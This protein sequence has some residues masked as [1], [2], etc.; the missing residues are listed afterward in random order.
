MAATTMNTEETVP[1]IW[2]ECQPPSDRVLKLWSE[3]GNKLDKESTVVW[4]QAVETLQEANNYLR[5][6]REARDFVEQY[7]V[8]IV[9]ILLD[10]QPLKVGNNERRCVEESLTLAVTIISNDLEI[11][12]ERGRRAPRGP[13]GV[14]CRT[15]D[16]LACVFCKKKQYYKG[17]K[18]SWNVNH[19]SGLPL[20]RL[21]LA[22]K[23]LEE[24]GFARLVEYMSD[25]TIGDEDSSAIGTGDP[26]GGDN[27]AL[28]PMASV[29]SPQQQQHSQQALALLASS[30][31]SFPTIDLLHQVLTV[32]LDVYNTN[33][34]KNDEKRLRALEQAAIDVSKATMRYISSCSEEALKKIPMEDL[35]LLVHDLLRIFDKLIEFRRPDTYDFYSFWRGLVLKLITSQSL[36]LKL[37]GWQQVETLLEASAAHR[38]PPRSFV[39]ELAG[40][41]FVNG[42][43]HFKGV[44]TEDGYGLRSGNNEISYVREIPDD[45]PVNSGK[46]LT[47]FRCTM[48]SQ[49]KW[50][51]LSEADE[52]Q[53][54]TDR[55]IDYY[56]HKSKEHEETEPPLS[57]WL[58]CR[59]A[60][61][62][63][64]PKLVRI[65]LMVP[66]GEERNTLEHQLARWAIDNKIIETLVLGDSVHREIVSRSVPLIK[67]L[68]SMC[69]RDNGVTETI[70]N[71]DNVA[72]TED[73]VVEKADDSAEYC[74]QTSHLLLAWK[75]CTRK[76]DAAVSA[77]IYQLLVSIL[78]SCPV[79]LAVVLLKAVQQSLIQG[80]SVGITNGGN[81]NNDCLTEVSD[82]C[83]ALAVANSND[84]PAYN[85]NNNSNRGTTS[86]Q[87]SNDARA[88]VLKLLWSL[89]IHPE[90]SSLKSYDLLKQYV[91]REL[92]VE[93]GGNEH[94]E[95]YLRSCIAA[96]QENSKRQTSGTVD[97]IRALKMV[98]L[99]HF[100]LEAC[101]RVQAA[102]LV[103]SDQGGLPLLLFDELTAFLKRKRQG[104]S[105]GIGIRAQN[106]P[107]K[108]PSIDQDGIQGT[109]SLSE[110]LGILRYV[111]G[112]SEQI[113]MSTPQLH[114][115]WQLCSAP[116]D[117][118]E[119]MAFIS[120]ASGITPDRNVNFPN[121][122][123]VVD[124]TMTNQGNKSVMGQAEDVLSSAFTEDE[125]AKAFVTL[126]CSSNIGYQQLGVKAYQSFHFMFN[127]MRLSA[128][129]GPAV[130]QAALDTLWR[131]CLES[132]NDT[133]ATS[134]MNDLLNSYTGFTVGNDTF[135]SNNADANDPSSEP[136]QT[137]SSDDGFGKRVFDCLSKVKD[138][139]EKK[140]PSAELAA[141]RCLRILNT[142]I[143]QDGSSSSIS[144]S[145]LNR[146][147]RSSPA[148]GLYRIS[149]CLPHGM[150]GQA[151]YRKIT[152][153]A[154]RQQQL[155]NHQGQMTYQE[156]EQPNHHS[157]RNIY[158]F[159]LDLHPLETMY[160]IKAKV[161]S[162][163][164][165]SVS[166]VKP[167]SANGRVSSP[168]TRK[169]NGDFS[170]MSPGHLP[171]D[172][173]VDEIGI[174]QGCEMV[175]VIQDRHNSQQNV[176]PGSA[177]ATRN[178]KARDLSD[179]FCDDSNDFSDKMFNTLL[180]V[181]D[182]LPW[183]EPGEMTDAPTPFSDTHKLVW[184]LL[185]AMPTNPVVSSQ[186][187]STAKSG[188][189]QEGVVDE[190]AM[191]IDSRLPDGWAKLL[192][193]KDF[194]RSVYVL[195]AID[196]F[197]QPAA[198]ILS[199]LPTEQRMILERA[200]TEDSAV[201][202]RGFIDS[203]GFD[204]VVGF[205]SFSED[206][207]E[208][209]QSMTRR[210]N[211]VALRILKCC[212]FSGSDSFGGTD[213]SSSGLD[214]AGKR[215]L[216]SLANAEGLLRS[217]TSMVVADSGISSSTVSDVLKFLCLLFKSPE[218]VKS[219]ASLPDKTAEKFLIRLLLWEGGSDT[220]KP[221]YS[222]TSISKVRIET[223]NLV[224]ATPLLADYALPWLKNA[225]DSIQ[226]TSECT[227]E[228]F[229]L[230]IKLVTESKN[231]SHGELNSLATTVCAKL[232]VCP[233]PSSEM[234]VLDFSTGVLC[235]CLGLLDALIIH[236][237]GSILVEGTSILLQEF[238][239]SRWSEM[240]IFTGKLSSD[241]SG[242]IDLMGVIFDAFL[243]PGGATS[244]VAIC[245]D[246]DSRQRGFDVVKSTASR[247]KEGSGYMALVHR[248]N[249]LISAATSF[250][251]HRWGQSTGGNDGV[252][253]NGRNSS[254]YSGLKNQGCT[255]YMNSVLQQL[256][257]M[258]E[259]RKSLCSAP[260]PAAIRASGGIVSSRGA[261]LVGRK[262]GMQW[263]SGN[264]Y[265]AIVEAFDSTSGMHTIR[266]CPT[267]PAASVG[268]SNHHQIH[269]EDVDSL[270][271]LLPEEFFL[272][273][274]RPGKETGVFEVISSKET[275]EEQG[276][277]AAPHGKSDEEIEETHDESSSRHLMEEVQRTFIHLEEGSRGRCFD[278]R[279][280]V[281]ACACLKLEFDVWQQNDA[282]EFSTKLLDRL[283]TS[284]KRWAPDSFRYLDHTFGIKQ[285]KQKICKE[286]GLKT[287]REEK[288]LNVICQ[289]R[290][291]AD[292]HEALSTMCETE[293]MEGN[294]QVFC[295]N[296]KKN[297]DTVL[298]SA[299]S[300]LPNM[301]ILSLKR[302]D[303][304]YNTFETV[305]LNSRCA[306][307][308]TLNMKRYT[309]EGVEAMEQAE[310]DDNQEIDAMDVGNE[311][312]ALSH[313]PDED[314]E[315]KLAGVLVHAGV[316]QGGHYYS[317]IN[318]RN[319]GSEDK[320]YRFDDE[321]VTAFDPA[322]IAT[323]CFGGKVKKETKWPNGQ[324]HS[325]ESEQF[326]NA[327]MLFYEKVKVSEHSVPE[328][329]EKEEAQEAELKKI[330][331]TTGYDVFEPDVRRSNA[332]HR[333]QSFLFNADFQTFLRSLL[334]LC[335]MSD[336]SS[337]PLKLMSIPN[338]S[339]SE[340]TV[341]KKS[342]SW[343]NE[344]I[345]ML[346]T[347]MF[348]VLQ[349]SSERLDLIDW[350]NTLEEIMTIERDCAQALTLKIASKTTSISGNWIRTYLLDCPDQYARIAS[351]R[352]F[353]AAIQSCLSIPEEQR[354]LRDWT[355]AWEMQLSQID[356][357]N[358][359]VPSLLRGKLSEYENLESPSASKIG[360]ILS[361]INTLIDVLP[362]C[363]R[364]NQEVFT[365]IRDL[366]FTRGG[367]LLRE[368]I[369]G[370]LIPARMV[371][372]V[373]RRK[374]PPSLLSAFP[375][376]SVSPDTAE[377]DF[378][379][380]QSH[381]LMAMNGNQAMNPSD[382]NFRGNSCIPLS[383]FESLGELMGIPHLHQATLLLEKTDQRGRKRLDL[384]EKAKSALTKIFEE[385]CA[386][387]VQ[388]MGQ[389]EIGEYLHKCGHDNVASQRIIDN[390]A[391]Y[392]P[393]PYGGNN[394][395]GV[396]HLNLAGFINYYRDVAQQESARVRNDL[397]LQGF[398]S[399]LS[400][401]P[402]GIRF[403]TIDGREE[404]LRRC[405]SIARDAA[406]HFH[407][408]TPTLGK[409]ADLGLSVFEFYFP[410]PNGC[411][412]AQLTEYI[413]TAVFLRNRNGSEA[414]IF[415][416]LKAIYMAPQGWQGGDIVRFAVII[417]NAL[418]SIPDDYQK[419]RIAFI[420][421]CNERL[422]VENHPLGLI[423]A[424]TT[425]RGLQRSGTYNH[426]ELYDAYERYIA[427]LKEMMNVHSVFDWMEENRHAWKHLERDLFEPS[428]HASHTGRQ[429]RGDYSGRRDND[430]IVPHLD[431]NHQSD[432]D[433][434]PGMNES[435]DDD[436]DSRFDDVPESSDVL[437]IRVSN[438]GYTHVNGLY[439]RDGRCEGVDKYSRLGLYKGT[440]SKFSIF[441][442]NVSNNTQH[443]YISMVPSNRE[444]GTV[445]DTDFYSAS[446]GVDCENLPPTIG[447]S[448]CS[449]GEDPAPTL[450][451][452][453]EKVGPT[454]VPIGNSLQG[455]IGQ[456]GFE[457]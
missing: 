213:F 181:L 359:P 366:S 273:E 423:S 310:I 173:V 364:Q 429:S 389:R 402:N 27:T 433:V 218:T 232:A 292:I 409:L 335:R 196:A 13:N 446:V 114:N 444:P 422:N 387:S 368:A 271:P 125:C 342:S 72:V 190:D 183:R 36:P 26:S 61:M 425:F 178:G 139:L 408:S 23:F 376:A 343:K 186:V 195:L 93:P 71:R 260:L 267:F 421:Q 134:A 193:L 214:E 78:P 20:T 319:P 200:M 147:S 318:D 95:T 175:F 137:E 316:A 52:E 103:T 59:N 281:E 240:P 374:S 252:S 102:N 309:L 40:C 74:L 41:N 404:M 291:K 306:F 405:E 18:G 311:E 248:I 222:V 91:T 420:M 411:M 272:S 161:A 86:S 266:Y 265:D 410:T 295:D 233:R 176:N 303:L 258:P 210:G 57:G 284:L 442:C 62:D 170:H 371:C 220:G 432:S 361:S 395:K 217:L 24:H 288:L 246:R 48:R 386:G 77:Q 356:T 381:H 238:K 92:R 15:L 180:G 126:F 325:V 47:L 379:P 159:S 16:V 34:N 157:E 276:R 212:L 308:Q 46:K 452:E 122:S 192:D 69:D 328:R 334:Y 50:W 279:A 120:S 369:I 419:K 397:S 111:Y 262:V 234:L 414:L 394:S 197:L 184:D 55:D 450:T 403:V 38:P 344:V 89:L 84:N 162:H 317:F 241:D 179:I 131:I 51:F 237:G 138:S 243:S 250:L 104:G 75:T 228:Y 331:M 382:L 53:P 155:Q 189:V 136:M 256:F 203:G 456:M 163:C 339:S 209:S 363:W 112:V 201:F 45:E 2:S 455:I 367:T 43:Y 105:S 224:L 160:S 66:P 453:R 388:G 133:V 30:A 88:E 357:E 100:V 439:E 365:F 424:S 215:L 35:K 17:T 449:D 385:S 406:S 412:S 225:I 293:I 208:M 312:S 280:L 393:V 11:Q 257:M 254:K 251:K 396:N 191:E 417:L 174:V 164:Q 351:V 418:A 21:I 144:I 204:A 32:L 96:L 207:P 67:F 194:S 145:T 391:K 299:I 347:F 107:R 226:V 123:G 79:N 333:W 268:G 278:P 263:E 28:S 274:G 236:V 375:G 305:K 118:E 9:S 297:T 132:R 211:A 454:P 298:R 99:T 349:Y 326:A 428:Q 7:M 354:K 348:D 108:S 3:V 275:K 5:I 390:I 182:A 115:L 399:D 185:L 156:R 149:K 269:H 177:R 128:S 101:P 441:K 22:E 346:V 277:R 98:K 109:I 285:T 358:N 143:G 199:C 377:Y 431:H 142:A 286:C 127:K 42:E 198:E 435:E 216:M 129:H 289:I 427:I 19:L 153:M 380:E 33:I 205:F 31:T 416:T 320:W 219:F 239:G 141:E 434:M 283:E 221:G 206:S 336:L 154:K 415:S 353:T 130:R 169:A 307:G 12:I 229:H 25:R 302:F 166:F 10:Q 117:R 426:H 80:S 65:G 436:D 29:S 350:V 329:T 338:L 168:S 413:V 187:L 54:G 398:R 4:T 152:V 345:D 392:N 140:D 341:T 249:G 352:I 383:L 330:R 188:D 296:C 87:L 8:Q 430:D 64:A 167:I 58:T 323:E 85:N 332:T 235:G 158:R 437:S 68:A 119:V 355:K 76:T 230:L 370:S 407:S 116:P 14:A 202:R 73:P 438:A 259:L 401:R 82:F 321:D 97:E 223:H 255:C 337:N 244:V 327:L 113:Y 270:P 440:N 290:G 146:I 56:Q 172:S 400:R 457:Q 378:K 165:C 110:R 451:F 124:P 384:S 148:D 70:D 304:D 44:E 373:N 151:C 135:R 94:R 83:E 372:F 60:G 362:R 121:N 448:K 6:S 247:C 264:T 106:P 37:F 231:V 313:L 63:P 227:A 324:V 315:Y 49:Q 242:L 314:Y 282:S 171:E 340:T 253:R 445:Q 294:N 90:A 443:W 287:N 245:C 39:V 150:R 261:E 1:Y 322:L 301:L 300:E 81:T 447:W 360:I